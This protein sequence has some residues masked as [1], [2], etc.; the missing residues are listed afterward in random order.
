MGSVAYFF[1]KYL[2][3]FTGKW[4]SQESVDEGYKQY[5]RSLTLIQRIWLKKDRKGD[6]MFG[7][8]PSIADLSLAS[9]LT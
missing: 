9:E 4:A 5:L 7:D 3:G 1:G 8:K 6:Y 2:S